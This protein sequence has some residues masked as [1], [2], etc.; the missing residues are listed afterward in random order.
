VI[1]AALGW[2]T[3]GS[4]TR[5][6]ATLLV[7]IAIGGTL[8][9]QVHRVIHD[10][11]QL[12]SQRE[13]LRAIE[14]A[15]A[16]TTRLQEVADAATRRATERTQTHQ[17]AA[18]GARAE[19]DRLRDQ[20]ATTG[21]GGSPACPAGADGADPA[22]ALLGACAAQ[23]VELGR[24]ADAHAA[25]ALRLYEAWPTHEAQAATP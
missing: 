9:H 21:P 14:A 17:R 11:A 13:T 2:L 24:A 7:G 3:G 12:Q 6:T 25:D 1:G 23:L 22:R 4:A 19:L 15:Q 8:A 10:R 18:A 16:E 20:L 5:T